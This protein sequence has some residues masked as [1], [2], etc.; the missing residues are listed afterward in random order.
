M[1]ERTIS[2]QNK[3]FDHTFS[4]KNILCKGFGCC[5]LT[6]NSANISISEI[7][8]FLMTQNLLTKKSV[9]ISTI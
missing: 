3:Y 9:Q 5:I 7:F 2:F 8:S 6:Q 4:D 1:Y